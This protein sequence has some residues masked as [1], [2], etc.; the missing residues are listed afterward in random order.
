MMPVSLKCLRDYE[1]S[2]DDHDNISNHEN[3]DH[4]NGDNDGSV[5]WNMDK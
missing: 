2:D 4:D 5:I 3:G 1:S